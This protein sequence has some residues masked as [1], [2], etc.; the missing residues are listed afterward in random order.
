MGS[1]TNNNKKN[2][3]LK[4]FLGNKNTVTVICV[5]I[6]IATLIIGYNIR[7]NNAISP[8]AVPYAL[9]EIKAGTKI[10]DDMIGKVNISS[11]FVNSNNNLIRSTA[12]VLNK[13]ATYKTNIPTGSL[14]FKEIVL[15]PSEMPNAAF[16]DIADGFTIYSLSVNKDSTLGN[17]IREGDFIDLYLSAKESSGLVIFSRF[18]ESIRVLAV[19]D[20]K[21]N[22]ILSNSLSSGTPSELL[23]AVPDDMYKL[24]MEAEYIDKGIKITPLLRNANYTAEAGETSVSSEYLRSFIEDNVFKTD[25]Y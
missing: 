2:N 13:Y 20:S 22:N 16:T 17:S 19:K 3:I 5:L 4:R 10:T 11:S 12:D 24:L 1:T 18:I 6:C 15:D 23:F 14:F 9:K 7:V 8:I 21:G 25:V